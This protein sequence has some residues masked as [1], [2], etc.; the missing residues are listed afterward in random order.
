MLSA[1]SIFPSLTSSPILES[2]TTASACSSCFT[3]ACSVVESR[4]T[5][6]FESEPPETIFSPQTS[7]H[8]TLPSCSSR[9]AAQSAVRICQSFM[10]P[11]MPLD[12]SCMP[13]ARKQTRSTAPVWPWNARMGV[14]SLMFHRRTV[15]SAEAEATT[16]S[17]GEKATHHTG[18][19]WPL[20]SPS[21]FPSGKSQ[22]RTSLSWPPEAMSLLLL[23]TVRSFTS[24]LWAMTVTFDLLTS[25]GAPF[26]SASCSALALASSQIFIVLSWLPLTSHT[27]SVAAASFAEAF[28][29]RLL[30]KDRAETAPACPLRT[31]TQRLLAVLQTR[32][33]WSLPPVA[34][35]CPSAD[36]SQEMT[37]SVWPR[38]S[39]A[40]NPVQLTTRGCSSLAMQTKDSG[41][42]FSDACGISCT[43]TISSLCPM[44]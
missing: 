34:I 27:G 1:A 7:M 23:D 31:L 8:Q 9:V 25:S 36:T 43:W 38:S 12:I 13:F 22:R 19:L 17:I 2:F 28:F 41:A 15:V 16:W 14:K 5:T 18:L 40:L 32:T 24:L 21:R 4:H 37:T 10:R 30:R 35:H 6:S 3:F 39:D 20:H 33:V 42:S 44:M 11:S 26:A 29:G